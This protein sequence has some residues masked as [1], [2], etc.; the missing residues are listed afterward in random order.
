M[1]TISSLLPGRPYTPTAAPK[2]RRL[3]YTKFPLPKA[4][5]WYTPAAG[6][7]PGEN[8]FCS[9]A[10]RWWCKSHSASSPTSSSM[11]W[12][13]WLRPRAKAVRSRVCQDTNAKGRRQTTAKATRNSD[14]F[15]HLLSR[16]SPTGPR[17]HHQQWRDHSAPHTGLNQVGCS[18]CNCE[19]IECG[20]RY[21]CFGHCTFA[22]TVSA[23]CGNV[24]APACI[25]GGGRLS[26]TG[27]S[28]G[29]DP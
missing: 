22:S 16:H 9:V 29:L 6:Q 18:P 12:T 11:G 8:T 25:R 3:V 10:R 17:Q 26:S 23:R 27:C 1:Y 19:R 2:A 4:R 14:F 20:Y 24:P 7:K 15:H 5:K 21:L 28:A 13:T